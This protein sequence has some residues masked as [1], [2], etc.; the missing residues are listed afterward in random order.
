MAIVFFI[1]LLQLRIMSILLY[2]VLQFKTAFQIASV[3]LH[4][5]IRE[6]T[7]NFQLKLP[8]RFSLP[9]QDYDFI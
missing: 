1:D 5:R 9:Q 3:A 7:K 8:E 4:F 6:N 2:R